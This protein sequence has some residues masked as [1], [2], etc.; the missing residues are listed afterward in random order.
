MGNGTLAAGTFIYIHGGIYNVAKTSVSSYSVSSIGTQTS[1]IWITGNPLN[2]PILEAQSLNV[3]EIA[4]GASYIVI[5]NLD[6]RSGGSIYI[7][8]SGSS[9]GVDHVLVRNCSLAGNSSLTDPNGVAIG[10]GEKMTNYVVIYN[11]QIK[12]FGKANNNPAVDGAESEQCGVYNDYNRRYTW[13]LGNTIYGV[14]ADC[15]AGSHNAND[16]DRP[17]E[18]VFIG[19]NFLANPNPALITSGEN[20]IDLKCTRYVVISQNYLRGPFGREQGWLAVTHSGSAPVPVRDCWFIFN[21]IHHGSAGIVTTSTNGAADTRIVGNLIYDIKNS[22]AAQ[23]DSWNGA[24]IRHM[25]SYGI[26][27]YIVDNTLFDYEDGII[28][29]NLTDANRCKVHGN[30]L[31]GRSDSNG[32]D[33]EIEV[34]MSFVA[35]DYNFWPS[36]ARI[37]WGNSIW[38]QTQLQA[39]TVHEDHG[40]SGDPLFNNPLSGDFSLK[41][42]S[43]AKDASVEGPVGSSIYEAFRAIYGE[44]IKKDTGGGVRPAGVAWDMGAYEADSGGVV[45]LRPSPPTGFKVVPK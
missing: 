25:V 31:H 9:V 43:L 33:L 26:N 23:S 34:G 21:T 16:T 5:E 6:M 38:T 18:Y 19:G 39:N 28:I 41:P 35:L 1:P 12:N 3:G 44:N 4:V 29:Q 14:G 45:S 8:P 10:G 24:A 30:I 17:A 22:Y 11:S 37:H 15:I 13:T 36:G 32:Y 27:N 20:A 40:L 2:K 7:R 42:D